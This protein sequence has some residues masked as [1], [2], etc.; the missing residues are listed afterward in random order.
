MIGDNLWQKLP[1]LE[2]ATDRSDRLVAGGD[3]QIDH[4]GILTERLAGVRRPADA[5]DAT[6]IEK[7]DSA[8]A[9]VL[10][11][12]AERTGITVDKLVFNDDHQ[13]LFDAVVEADAA[14]RSSAGSGSG[15]ASVSSKDWVVA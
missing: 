1:T 2:M 10:A 13:A 11:R 15:L 7:L 3:W 6:A 12:F 8:G 4:L 14:A 5:I 9:L